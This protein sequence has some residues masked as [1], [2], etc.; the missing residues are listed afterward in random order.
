MGVLIEEITR[1]KKINDLKKVYRKCSVGLRNES[2][3]EHSWSCLVLA[4]FLLE[5]T[6]KKLNRTKVYELLIY[7]DFLEIQFGDIPLLPKVKRKSN[8]EIC[9][10]KD[11]LNSFPKTISKRAQLLYY[12][13]EKQDSL[14]SKFAKLVDSLDPII[15]ELDYPEDWSDW[16]LDFFVK[17]KSKYFKYFPELFNV[18]YE[19]VS[20]LLKEGFL[21]QR[22]DY[23][24]F[25]S[26]SQLSIDTSGKGFDELFKLYTEPFMSQEFCNESSGMIAKR[27]NEKAIYVIENGSRE[28]YDGRLWEDSDIEVI[29]NMDYLYSLPAWDWW[30]NPTFPFQ[31]F[32]KE[33]L[34]HEKGVYGYT[35]IFADKNRT[36]EDFYVKTIEK[37]GYSIKSLKRLYNENDLELF[38][39]YDFCRVFLPLKL[40]NELNRVKN[41]ISIFRPQKLFFIL[42]GGYFISEFFKESDFEISFLNPNEKHEFNL[43]G[44]HIVDDC[45]VM[46]RNIAKL[47]LKEDDEFF[48][49]SL[50]GVFSS[51]IYSKKFPGAHF[52]IPNSLFNPFSCRLFEKNPFL[53]GLDVVND[54][55]KEYHS[56]VRTNFINEINELMKR[57]DIMN[58]IYSIALS[59]LVYANG[60]YMNNQF[61]KSKVRCK[62]E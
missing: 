36:K 24:T 55:I 43:I 8:P 7:H 33:F 5:L 61:E 44:E 1:L 11:F 62:N 48:I 52:D 32:R 20:F 59:L 31:E 3:A 21:D 38:L 30:I 23:L 51:E 16:N 45:V 56:V 42:R 29:L 50:D 37:E 35:I 22:L 9:E 49:H 53:I 47:G 13:F 18:F 12:E 10:I 14:E 6:D 60:G 17:E 26:N 46:C 54:E 39:F 57:N 34:N 28:L 25:N 15:N 2:S 41:N 4:D 27:N 19:L 40:A 58:D